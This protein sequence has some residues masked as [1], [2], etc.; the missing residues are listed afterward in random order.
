MIFQN[1]SFLWGFFLLL[2]PVIVHLFDFRRVKKV[3]FSNVFFLKKLNKEH[4]PKKRMRE[5]LLLFCRLL[6]VFFLVFTFSDPRVQAE[7]DLSMDDAVI[8]ID[9]SFSMSDQCGSV[10]CLDEAIELVSSIGVKSGAVDYLGNR[11]AKKFSNQEE[12]NYRAEQI[13]LVKHS[14]QS[15]GESGGTRLVLSDFQSSVVN[16]IITGDSQTFLLIPVLSSLTSNVYVDSVFTD[17]P[18]SFASNS[19]NLMVRLFNSGSKAVEDMIVRLNSLDRQIGTRAVSISAN[20][21]LMIKFDLVVEDERKFYVEIEDG[22][23]SFD[24][25]YYFSL[26]ETDR[27][28]IAIILDRPSRHLEALFQNEDLFN[29]RSFESDYI[30]FEFV[31][32]ADLVILNEFVDIPVWFS[33]EKV[34]GDVVVIPAEDANLISYK[35]MLGLPMTNNPDSIMYPLESEKLNNPFISGVFDSNDKEVDL[36]KVRNLFKIFSDG[37]ELLRAKEPFLTN[38]LEGIKRIYVFSAPLR[39]RYSEFQNHSLF[40]PVFFRMVEESLKNQDQLAYSLAVENISIR[41]SA[42]DSE[43]LK[44]V[45]RDSEYVVQTYPNEESL[46]LVVPDELNKPGHYDMVVD[47]DTVG[48]I[49]LNIP[50]VES[51]RDQKNAYELNDIFGSRKNVIVIDASSQDSLRADLDDMKRGTPLWK[52][53]LILVLIFLFAETIIHRW[54]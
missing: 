35:L 31:F 13:E 12:F 30:D 52:Y 24:N 36:P 22:Y 25:I 17:R 39:R 1:P 34:R 32:D 28:K 20:E 44:L 54:K 9:N 48:I 4:F 27:P 15:F 6:S 41:T 53:A 10:T 16:E 26:E 3:E 37:N 42:I 46:I 11:T 2:I 29:S 33:L 8:F 14:S 47:N 23:S 50:E 51:I 45:G 43:I 7:S 18:L 49:S 5:L 40:V 19:M 21:S 38:I